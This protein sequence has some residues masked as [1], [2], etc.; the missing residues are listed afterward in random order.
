VSTVELP[1]EL[2]VHH[3]GALTSVQD[4]GRFGFARY[5][6]PPSGVLDPAALCI[7]NR[8]VGNDE[9]CAGLELNL[10]G[11][12]LEPTGDVLIAVAGGQF[13]PAPGQPRLVR[14]HERL[15]L[16][17]GRGTPRAV[18]AVR[19]GIDVPLALAS[20]STCLV[21]GFGG[22]HGRT[23][24]EG[25]RL[26]VGTQARYPVRRLDLG[27]V[28][29][30]E[31]TSTLRFLPGPAASQ[32]GRNLLEQF[33][34]QSWSVG[35]ESDRTGFRL[36]GSRLEVAAQF[37]SLAPIPTVTG[38]IQITATGQPVVLL[39]ERP[40]TGGYPQLGTVIAADLGSLV[41]APFGAQLRF[42]IVD[43]DSAR[44]ALR[45]QRQQLEALLEEM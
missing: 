10:Q 41:R 33:A 1:V 36:D 15:D 12:V 24:R 21:G 37:A 11:P 42:E 4:L 38:T 43:H 39:C 27:L 9:N 5:G 19:G 34:R 13:G 16:R 2:I 45:V 3:P 28:F 22:W 17:I 40:V 8:L 23:L 35:R 7:A 18:M 20:R 6:V 26:A 14:A 31:R 32:L 29:D 25:D 44:R 30:T